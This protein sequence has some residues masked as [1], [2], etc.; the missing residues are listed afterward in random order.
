[1]DQARSAKSPK[2]R[3]TL[4][5]AAFK[6]VARDRPLIYLW[7]PNNYT[8]VLSNVSGVSVFGD[9]LIRPALAQ[10]K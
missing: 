8:G 2:A 6:I 9:G 5:N 10:F 4:Y 1:M 3:R 7:Y